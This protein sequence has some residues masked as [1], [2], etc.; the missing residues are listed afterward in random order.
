MSSS[1]Q[2]CVFVQIHEVRIIY[3]YIYIS[4]YVYTSWPVFRGSVD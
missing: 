2:D 1:R 4:I 3:V